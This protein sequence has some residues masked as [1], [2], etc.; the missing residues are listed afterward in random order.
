MSDFKIWLCGITQNCRAD[1]D[2]LTKNTYKHF[3]GLVWVDHQSIDGTKELL[4]ERKEEGEI[5]SLPF[6]KNHGWSMQG[7]LNSDK[8]LPGDFVCWRDSKERLNENWTL[9]LRDL[10]WNLMKQNI[11]TVF[12]YGKLLLFRYYPEMYITNSPHWGMQNLRPY[13][14]DMS[15]QPQFTD[16]K[17][18]AWNA[19]NETRSEDHWIFHFL[20]YLYQYK[21][22]NHLLLGREQNLEEFRVHEE[23]RQKFII[24]C[25]RELEIG[26]SASD[27]IDYWKKNELTYEM[28]WFINF[29]KILND[30]YTY[31]VL[32]HPIELL[33]ER[34][35]N[36][37]L[38]KI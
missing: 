38:Y 1:I 35:K 2:A 3:N 29:E 24:Y 14:V 10:C 20:V 30:A 8:I 16:A 23:V 37:E 7:C 25:R 9:N 5:I 22:S 33:L 34:A 4:E 15:Q 21:I 28:K 18:Y 19:R 11:N 26:A 27:L 12:S 13:M 6:L 31:F 17:S 32:N 36:K